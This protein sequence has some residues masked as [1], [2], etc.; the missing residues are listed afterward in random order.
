MIVKTDN[1]QKQMTPGQQREF[2]IRVLAALPLDIS[3]EMAQRWI[4]NPK[5]LK[6]AL[7]R[8]FFPRLW[9][10]QA[11]FKKY[12]EISL[13]LSNL[14]IPPKQESFDR[15]IIIPEGITPNKIYEAYVKNFSCW[16][17]TNDLNN[18]V[19]HNDREPTKTY[20]VWVRDT[21]E[22]DEENENIS[23]DRAKE[24]KIQGIT[25]IERLIFGLKYW[26]E[27]KTHLDVK[28]LTICSGSRSSDGS[29]PS[30]NCCDGEVNV[31][32]CYSQF[33]G[34]DWRVRTVVSF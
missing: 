31:N 25:L 28:N 24:R 18:A 23:A 21:Q 17:W 12:L 22:A 10:W 27:T 11:F 8:V 20:A 4:R 9:D 2:Y 7:S 3:W 6:Q 26:D 15:L 33:A 19:A 5:D 29:V 16:K 30:V 1:A 14:K 32:W 34:S 13:D